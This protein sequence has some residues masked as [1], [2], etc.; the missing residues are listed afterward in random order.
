MNGPIQLFSDSTS[1]PSSDSANQLASDAAAF[2]ALAQLSPAQYD[3]VRKAEARRLGIRIETLSILR[4]S[5][6]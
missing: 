2:E 4:A 6:A 3:R 1:S 5:F